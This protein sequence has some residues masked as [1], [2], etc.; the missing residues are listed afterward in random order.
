MST[1]SKHIGKYHVLAEL[2]RGG[3]SQVYLA[4]VAGPGGFNKL[5]VLKVLLDGLASDDPAFIQMFL[6]EA[7]LA[8][9]LNHANIVQTN[10]VGSEDESYFIAME[11]L[12]GQPFHRVLRRSTKGSEKLALPIFLH[13]L[14]KALEGLHAAHTAKDFDGTPLRVVHRDASPQNVF[15]TYDGQVKVM[16]FGIAKATGRAGEATKAGILKGKVVYMAPE[17]VDGRPVDQRADVFAMGVVLFDYLAGQRLW[18]G[19]SEVEVLSR[20]MRNEYERSPRVA[21]PEIAPALDAICQRA[22]A[23]NPADR[24]QDARAMHDDI[25]A[26]LKQAGTAPTEREVGDLVARLFAR[27]R[28][29]IA[30]IVDAQLRSLKDGP[31]LASAAPLPRLQAVSAESLTPPPTTGSTNVNMTTSSPPVASRE[32]R[33]RPAWVLPALAIGAALVVGI[34]VQRLRAADEKAQATDLAP[35]RHVTDPS[36]TAESNPG[37][38]A[39]SG[40][41]VAPPTAAETASPSVT[42]SGSTPKNTTAS[43]TTSATSQPAPVEKPRAGAGF[44]APPPPPPPRYQ[45]PPPRTATATAATAVPST[46]ASEPA[47]TATTPPRSTKPDLGY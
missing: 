4:A 2:G 47:A 36:A 22:L 41:S 6:D 42:P 18:A 9:R 34:T 24:Y 13:V 45:P 3:M 37:T 1:R 7:R 43:N 27:E 23:P 31:A 15:V 20:L 32:D 46:K 14:A 44:V 10:E 11:Y 40:E 28:G 38:R 35:A 19:L 26:F 12:E 16:D 33:R 21:N 17:Q 39:P 25:Q 5:V 29:E 30:R 8:A